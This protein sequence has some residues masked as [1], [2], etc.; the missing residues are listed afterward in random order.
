LVLLLTFMV[1]EVV[2][3]LLAGSLALL[4]D[5]GHMISDAAAIALALFAMRLAARPAKG[6]YTFGLK[7]AEIL[8]A[9]A[10]G[11]TLIGLAIY[12]VVESIIRL[13]TPPE[14]VGLL[15]V[16]VALVGVAMNLAATMVLR[17]A[18][19]SS[20]NVEGTF[21]HILTDLYA[22]IG[23]LIAG[24]VVLTT[25]WSR[26]DAVASL[27]VAALM[28]KA[29]YEL[30][31]E[32]GRVM[33]E[34]APRGIDPAQV[35]EALLAQ[36]GVLNVHELHIWEVTSGFPAL[37][38]HVTVD[39]AHDCHDRRAELESVLEGR[40]HISHTTLQVDHP[41]HNSHVDDPACPADRPHA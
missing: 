27:F 10:N 23:T 33:L 35:H 13:V 39:G 6:S 28:A 26:A 38:A 41:E 19:R 17:K 40:F 5:A 31:R 24:I 20:L 25:G 16:I 14:V 3:G 29:G 2:V 11:V 12:F 21:Q 34:A 4:A 36:P 15:V 7:R 22:F 30:L 32:S 9:M 1:G 18:N 37:S 8:S